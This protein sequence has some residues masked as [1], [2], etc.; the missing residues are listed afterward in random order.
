MLTAEHMIPNIYEQSSDM[1]TVCRLID[2]E[3]EILEYYTNHILDCY[4]PEHCP[5]HLVEELAT[6]IGFKYNDLKH[7]CTTE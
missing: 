1:R 3:A 5:N 4:S 7:L 6:H 2:A